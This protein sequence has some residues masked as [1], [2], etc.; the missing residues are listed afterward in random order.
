MLIFQYLSWHFFEVPQKIL[1]AWKNFLKFGLY[2]FSIPLLL[3]TIFYWW[4]GYRWEYPKSFD[5]AQF[6]LVF[7]SN[8][9][10]RTIG[11]ILRTIVILIG[12]IFEISIFVLG[13]LVFLGWLFLPFLLILS[14][15][16]SF[17]LIQGKETFLDFIFKIQ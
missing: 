8:L 10:T 14:L 9:V 4:H 15:I 11:A 2:Y 5:V 13:L 7:L 12:I 3:K 1:K 16:L 17:Q 6:V